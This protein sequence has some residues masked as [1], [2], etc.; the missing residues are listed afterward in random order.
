MKKKKYYA[1]SIIIVLLIL[2]ITIITTKLTI[3]KELLI[4]KYAYELI[5]LKLRNDTLTPIMKFTTKLS[6]TSIIILI[7]ILLTIIISLRKNIKTA[8][9][10]PINLGIIAI[11]NQILKFIFQRPRPTGF[12]LIEIGGFSFPSGHAMGST[13]FYGL[14]IY[15][16]YKL[17]KN[18]TLKI[19]SIILNSLIIIGIGI[20]RIYLGVHY[21]SDVVVGIS[22]TIIYLIIFIRT[23]EKK[24]IIQD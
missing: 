12:R 15:L 8:S 21:C 20:S 3:N 1:I 10:I 22:L 19:I 17:I 18:K 16:S 11:I 2:I 6:N 9:L 24:K 23:I 14:L 5:V 13:A 7:A 4:D